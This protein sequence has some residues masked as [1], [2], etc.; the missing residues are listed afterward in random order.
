MTELLL[1]RHGQS[2]FNA[3]RRW[4]NWVHESPLTQ[5]GESEAQ[6]LAD[7]LV[8]ESD[9]AAIYASPLTRAAQTA[10]IIGQALG[11]EPIPLAGLREVDVGLVGGLTSDEFEAR[12]PS[13]FARWRDR[14]DL[15]F[16]W[17]G[18]EVRF[19]FFQRAAQAVGEV[20]AGHAGEKVVVVCHGGVIRATLA[21]YLPNDFSEWWSYNLHTGSLSRLE[22]SPAGNQL[23]TLNEYEEVAAAADA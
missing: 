19:D 4:E 17:P 7:R 12:F 16:T 15:G 21:F 11:M 8:A 9:V 13:A 5:Q 18:G 6:A 23:L 14:R 3:E 10:Q 22:V 1:V 20:V 2:Q